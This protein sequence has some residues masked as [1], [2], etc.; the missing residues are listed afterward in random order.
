MKN[1]FLFQS[2]IVVGSSFLIFCVSAPPKKILSPRPLGGDVGSVAPSGL[3]VL[4]PVGP[5]SLSTASSAEAEDSEDQKLALAQ[6]D[7]MIA[8]GEDFSSVASTALPS[9]VSSGNTGS[10]RRK[11]TIVGCCSTLSSAPAELADGDDIAKFMEEMAATVSD[12][13]AGDVVAIAMLDEELSPKILSGDCLNVGGKYAGRKYDEVVSCKALL[14]GHRKI[15][16]QFCSR[17]SELIR[18]Y[19]ARLDAI[20][21]KG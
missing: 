1:N 3:A 14:R 5:F 15:I 17:S 9:P 18:A 4:K 8:S 16:M 10:R 20:V 11:N 12:R 13:V 2:I 21:I 6:L 19:C 7:E